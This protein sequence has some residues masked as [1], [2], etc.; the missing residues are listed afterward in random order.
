MKSSPSI[1]HFVSK[2]Q[3]DGEDFGIF[4]GLLRKHELYFLHETQRFVQKNKLNINKVH[5]F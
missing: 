4:G 1:W 3:I 2:H 5:V